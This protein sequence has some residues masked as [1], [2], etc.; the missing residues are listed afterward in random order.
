MGMLLVVGLLGGERRKHGEARHRIDADEGLHRSDR[1]LEHAADVLRRG[2]L[3]VA[4]QR[5]R[6]G[7]E[8]EEHLELIEQAKKAI[9]DVFGDTSVS[10]AQVKE[11]LQDLISDIEITLSTLSDD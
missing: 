6:L 1:H 5:L 2:V 11:S 10:R 8:A 4:G 9:N 7:G 3:L